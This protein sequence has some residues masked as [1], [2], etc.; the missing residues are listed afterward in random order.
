[1][2]KKVADTRKPKKNLL[3]RVDKTLFEYSPEL[4]AMIPTALERTLNQRMPLASV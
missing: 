2:V 1:M 3:V 4:V